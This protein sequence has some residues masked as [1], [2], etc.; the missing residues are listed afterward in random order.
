MRPATYQTLSPITHAPIASA[1]TATA[2][3]RPSAASA[4]ATMSVGSAGTGKPSCSRSTLKKTRL[5]PKGATEPSCRAAVRVTRKRLEPGFTGLP[6]VNRSWAGPG[7]VST[8]ILGKDRGHGVIDALLRFRTAHAIKTLV[9]RSV[10][11]R[12]TGARVV[13]VHG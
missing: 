9:D 10:P 1:Q 4:P 12:L 5:S 3:S 13:K 7:L 2:E 11:Q 6:T 8:G